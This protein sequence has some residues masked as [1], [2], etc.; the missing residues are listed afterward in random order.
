MPG[1]LY[2]FSGWSIPIAILC[3]IVFTIIINSYWPILI[4]MF[5]Y[6]QKI[7]SETVDFAKGVE[8]IQDNQER[9]VEPIN[10]LSKQPP[11]PKPAASSDS[12]SSSAKKSDSSYCLWCWTIIYVF[13]GFLAAVFIAAVFLSLIASFMEP[14]MEPQCEKLE[15]QLS[16]DDSSSSWGRVSAGASIYHQVETGMTLVMPC[17]GIGLDEIGNEYQRDGA[18]KLSCGPPVS[19]DYVTG[20]K[21]WEQIIVVPIRIGNMRR[22]TMVIDLLRVIGVVFGVTIV[23]NPQ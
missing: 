3:A 23:A 1:L 2:V 13:C 21:T 4:S 11:G 10:M 9:G 15:R 19:F 8:K 5:R 7:L 18:Y 14:V 22:E 20:I 16:N 6:L 12:T 17:D